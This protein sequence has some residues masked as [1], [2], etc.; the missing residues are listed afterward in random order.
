MALNWRLRFLLLLI[1]SALGLLFFY[2][3]TDL[4][5]WR[6]AGPSVPLTDAV[7]A[8][9][10]ASS[11]AILLVSAFYP[12]SKSKHTM[13]EYETWLSNFLRPITTDMYFYTTPEMESLVRKCR[14]NLTITID[15][16]FPSPFDIGP[17][18]S[19]RE[20]YSEMH[21]IDREKSRH[22]PELYAIW[23]AKPFF[24]DEAVQTLARSGK[25]YD[26][27]FWSDAGSFRTTHKYVAWPSPARVRKLWKQGSEL[28][29]EKE[30]DLLFFPVTGM[31]H[32]SMIY[33]TQDHGPIDT[34]FSEGSFFGGSPSTVA[35]WRGTYYAYHDYYMGL[36][37]F[38]GKDQTV[39]NALFVLFPSRIIS[40]WLDDP[41]A[42]EHKSL[43]SLADGA[44]GNC[45]PEWYY[46]Q[47][48]L[49][50]PS[51]RDA[52]RRMWQS[53]WSWDFWRSRQACRLT[54]VSWMKELL[55]RIFG[56]GW[57]PPLHTIN[58]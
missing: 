18:S 48:F 11:T 52:M 28:T 15:T 30:E 37:L 2:A 1:P 44:L 20:R 57:Q 6:V 51:E 55:V 58:A 27:A 34:E 4:A 10:G 12:L 53:K 16:T 39:I 36:G 50:H 21:R 31:P 47:F 35:W 33:W 17:L 8:D 46:Y 22:S 25:K 29:E 54:R 56:A 45:G 5:T 38:V 24:L 14:G 40:V 3:P 13:R 9:D 43:P 19:A 41:E 49:A 26:Y 32:S 23:A 42:P 7:D